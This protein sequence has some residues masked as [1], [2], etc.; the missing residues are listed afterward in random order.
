MKICYD[1][2]LTKDE[3]A[4]LKVVQGLNSLCLVRF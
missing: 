3:R 2:S 4:E 1:N